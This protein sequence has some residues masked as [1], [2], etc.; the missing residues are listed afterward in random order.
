MSDTTSTSNTDLALLIGRICFAPLFL[1][2]AY[3]KING[4]PAIVTTLTN[5]GAP[6]PLVGGY[7]A[8]AAE[9]LFPLMLILGV[10]TRWACFGLILYTLGT[11]VIG[12]RFWDFTGPQHFTQL[13]AFFKNLALCGGL[14]ALAWVGP[15]RFALQPRP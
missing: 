9:I 14:L 6:L 7:V 2:S 4:W 11:M 1:I 3:G 8:I 13:I 5:Q 15:G 10:K 12:H